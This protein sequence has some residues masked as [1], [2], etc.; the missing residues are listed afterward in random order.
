MDEAIALAVRSAL[1]DR[2]GTTRRRSRRACAHSSFVE[3]MYRSK[4]V[5]LPYLPIA[6]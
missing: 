5:R 6:A 1:D 2:Q 3:R 4:T